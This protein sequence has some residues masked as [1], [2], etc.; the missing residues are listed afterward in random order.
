VFRRPDRPTSWDD[1]VKACKQL[2]DKQRLGLVEA[3]TVN[4]YMAYESSR[5]RGDTGYTAPPFAPPLAVPMP[6]PQVQ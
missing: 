1:G 6:L 3:A 2:S 5:S 4:A